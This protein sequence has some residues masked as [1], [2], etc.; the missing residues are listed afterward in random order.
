MTCWSNLCPS[1]QSVSVEEYFNYLRHALQESHLFYDL[2]H[3]PQVSLLAIISGIVSLVN[4]FPG[5]FIKQNCFWIKV[6]Y[7]L[8]TCRNNV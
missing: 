1:L 2:P 8:N 3:P 6:L 7:S 4:L 5:I